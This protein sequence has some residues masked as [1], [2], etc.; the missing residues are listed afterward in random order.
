MNLKGE[1][2][3]LTDRRLEELSHDPRNIVMK[4]V[5]DEKLDRTLTGEELQDTL[6]HIKLSIH[7]LYESYPSWTNPQIINKACR[8]DP[9]IH[10]F[11]TN[12]DLVWTMVAVKQI[13]KETRRFINLMIKTRKRID[14]GTLSEPKGREIILSHLEVLKKQEDLKK[15]QVKSQ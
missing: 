1:Q 12:Y 7:S 15:T 5:A 11:S 2:M 3:S 9:R 14:A 6:D 10:H 4:S 13:P 8:D